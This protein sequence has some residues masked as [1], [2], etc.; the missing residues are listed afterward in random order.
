MGDI[1]GEIQRIGIRSSTVRT[2]QGAEVII[3][4]ADLIS[5]QVTNW[6][7]SD[8]RRRIEI[9]VGVAYGTDPHRV[10][11]I[12]LDIMGEVEGILEDPSPN[13]IFVGFGESSLD[14]QARAWTDEFDQ[15]TRVKSRL[16]IRIIDA[17]Q[18]AGVE[19]PF[20]QRDLHLR[21]SDIPSEA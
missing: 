3:P 11:E 2:W 10:L 18:E 8:R 21:S 1:V 13:I 12:L 9:D 17:L 6:T 5:E 15:F 7:R 20:P 19:I 4:N 16:G 14:F